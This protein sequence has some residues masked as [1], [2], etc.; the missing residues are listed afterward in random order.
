PP[1][2]VTSLISPTTR[3]SLSST[4]ISDTQLKPFPPTK[5]EEKYFH[6]TQ[7]TKVSNER[8]KRYVSTSPLLGCTL[9]A[10]LPVHHREQDHVRTSC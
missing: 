7:S 2:F 4:E 9:L 6:Q 5:Q 3:F 10:E 8:H 1:H